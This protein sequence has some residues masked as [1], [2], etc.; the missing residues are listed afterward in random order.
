M[1]NEHRVET[2]DDG[3]WQTIGPRPEGGDEG[4]QSQGTSDPP[5]RPPGGSGGPPPSGRK[6]DHD[7]GR[8]LA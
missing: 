3:R 7:R 5:P 4:D 2:R 8:W 6:H 1:R